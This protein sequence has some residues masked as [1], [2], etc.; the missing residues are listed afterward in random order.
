MVGRQRAQAL[1]AENAVEPGP[2]LGPAAN[3]RHV[4][5]RELAGLLAEPGVQRNA[6]MAG[7]Q[8]SNRAMAGLL[9]GRGTQRDA[10]PGGGGGNLDPSTA[11]RI[12]SARGGGRP[13]P[14]DVRV[15]LEQSMG[16]DLTGVRVH[17]DATAAMLSHSV[18]AYAFTS[19]S[20]IFFSAGGYAPGSSAG[21][22]L[23]AHETVHVAQQQ[24]GARLQTSGRVSDPSDAAEVEAR[25]LAP[26]LAGAM[27]AT[28][29]AARPTE[30]AVPA[31]GGALRQGIHRQEK[32]ASPAPPEPAG[33]TTPQATS[34]VAP[35]PSGSTLE[36]PHAEVNKKPVEAVGADLHTRLDRYAKI[37]PSMR[38]GAAATQKDEVD[39][40]ANKGVGGWMIEAWNSVKPTDPARWDPVLKRWD[41]ADVSLKTALAVP[42]AAA[43][44]N[45]QGQA[46][47]D[48][49]N[50]WQDAAEQTNTRRA[51]YSA[52]LR[53]FSGSAESLIAVSTTV[54][55]LSFAAAVGIAVVVA[56]PVVA[57]AVGAFGTGTLGLTAGSTGLAAFTYAGTGLAMGGL[58]AGMEG[59]GQAAATLGAQASMA[60]SDLVRGQSRA[61]D[62]FD[63]GAIGA[64]GWEGVKRGF[65]DGVLAF[66]GAEA[67]KVIASAGGPALRALFGPG[68][69]SFLAL[70][71]RRTVQRAASAGITGAV[72]G[73]LQAGYRA[74]A[75]GQ[76]L[77]GIEASM[78][79]GFLIGGAAGAVLGGAGGA[80]EARGANQLRLA[81]SAE[82]KA[83]AAVSP[84]SIEDDVLVQ[85]TLAKLRAN[86]T[87]ENQRILELT[88]RAW[89]ALHDP[90]QI[91]SALAEIWLEEH[92]LSVLAPQSAEARFGAAAQVLAKRRGAPVRILPRSATF[93]AQDFFDQVVVTGDRFLD[94]SALSISPEHGA[95][96]HMVQDL[97]VDNLLHGTGLRAEQYR[98]L[99]AN[100]T[101]ADGSKI[102]NDL[103]VELYDSFQGRINQ[104]EVVYP[105][106][107]KAI[108]VP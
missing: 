94:Y 28:P 63:L 97:A 75:E 15:P 59:A 56:A 10:A 24:Q 92:L 36:S 73:A 12:D 95:I 46:A 3:A 5:N 38:R 53:A 32:P 54:R 101:A 39:W 40:Y 13:L 8:L 35:E 42:V 71:L 65:V 33:M 82:L 108:K 9:S 21:R 77:A 74:A 98:Q 79:H 86:P 11:A 37:T 58:G 105:A 76:D 83:T 81:V 52:Y 27:G 93:S 51:E 43:K 23:I 96:T 106:M 84:A 55:D 80:W 1:A 14:E 60:M 30:T 20:H 102:G 87:P 2:N 22:E 72:I 99:F 50:V 19:G 89:T 57:G 85:A 68:N 64:Q 31:T 29:S 26:G 6:I 44:I 78:K 16:T 91:G 49:L 70:L 62:N 4:G 100:A 7:Q 61:A 17:T 69:S 34:A 25:R 18:D 90:D 66:A 103:W 88:P 45:Q 104:P 41:D 47:Q 107:R 67:E 48:A